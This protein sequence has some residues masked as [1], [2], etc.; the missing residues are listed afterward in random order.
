MVKKRT[1]LFMIALAIALVILSCP[2]KVG[3]AA[4]DGQKEDV[5]KIGER[6]V[7]HRSIVSLEKEVAIGKQY[8]ADIDRFANR[9]SPTPS[10]LFKS[11]AQKLK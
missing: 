9:G 1:L 8:A 4:N 2:R 6:K 10:A 11:L 5:T 3:G 7:A